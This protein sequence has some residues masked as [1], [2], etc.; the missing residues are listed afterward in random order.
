MRISPKQYGILL[1]E[2]TKD[3]DDRA[4]NEVVG[5]FLRLLIKNRNLSLLPKIKLMYQNYYNEQEGEADVTITALN[6][7]PKSVIE[8]IKKQVGAKNINIEINIDKN[9]LGGSVIRFGDYLV[10]NTLRTKLNL[11]SRSLS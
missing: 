1:Y 6:N 9:I 3:A 11:L 2:L 7:A 4:I 5:Q 10:D 8:K